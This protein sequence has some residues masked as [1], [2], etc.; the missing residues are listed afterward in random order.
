MGFAVFA[1]YLFAI[2]AVVSGV[3]VISARNPVHSVLWL[4]LAFFSAAGLFVLLGAEFVAMLM[5][6]VYVGA[7][8]VLFLFVVMMLDVD[9]AALRAGV[10]R[11]L[12]IGLLIG[13]VLLVQLGFAFGAWEL[14]DEA[15]SLRQAVTP[16]PDQ[17]HNTAALGDLLYTRYVLLFQLAGLVLL[18]AMVGAIVLTL[19]KRVYVKRQSV[20]EQ[21]YRDPK[22]AVELLD[23]KPGQGA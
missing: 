12:P 13:L 22:A 21:M 18:V 14:S 7:V 23:I 9:F 5:L 2:V 10:A 3:L 19:R 6:I 20:V 17:V 8:A 4:I 11:Y 16:P 1:F 15:L